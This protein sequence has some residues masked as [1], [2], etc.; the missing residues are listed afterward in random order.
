MEIQTQ[1]A[2]HRDYVLDHYTYCSS[3]FNG[4]DGEVKR[5]DLSSSYSTMTGNEKASV[6][7][8]LKCSRHLLFPSLTSMPASSKGNF[9]VQVFPSLSY[10]PQ[11][12]CSAFRSGNV[13]QAFVY[14]FPLASGIVLTLVTEKLRTYDRATNKNDLLLSGTLTL[15]T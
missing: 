8:S 2:G 3:V 7:R 15:E 13:T 12:I 10:A 14:H 4:M 6:T 1:Q 9:S 5:D 11:F